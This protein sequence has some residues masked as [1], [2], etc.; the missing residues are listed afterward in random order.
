MKAAG[1]KL[2]DFPARRSVM[3]L[4]HKIRPD[5]VDRKELRI[6]Y[7]FKSMSHDGQRAKQHSEQWRIGSHMNHLRKN[8]QVLSAVGAHRA[9]QGHTLKTRERVDQVG[10]VMLLQLVNF[11]ACERFHE[12]WLSNNGLFYGFAVLN[13]QLIDHIVG[14]VLVNLIF[15]NGYRLSEPGFPGQNFSMGLEA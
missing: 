3:R 7:I 9:N 12:Q 10:S 8:R 14:I 11:S 6:L 15:G 1:I 13:V 4:S 5:V 2:R